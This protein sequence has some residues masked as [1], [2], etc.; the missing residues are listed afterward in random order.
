MAKF[1]LEINLGNGGMQSD[2]NIAERLEHVAARLRQY[3]VD[4]ARGEYPIRDINGNV[5]GKYEV[6][7]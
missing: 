1:I 7:E 6:T 5:V 2:E 4:S 3:G